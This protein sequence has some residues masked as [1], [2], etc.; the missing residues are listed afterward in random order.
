MRD[1]RDWGFTNFSGLIRR[2]ERTRRRN[3]KR[4]RKTKTLLIRPAGSS[5]A[6]IMTIRALMLDAMRQKGIIF[7]PTIA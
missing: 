5:T 4:P 6:T 2:K 7:A 3:R 1:P